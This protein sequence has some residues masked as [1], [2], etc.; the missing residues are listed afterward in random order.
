MAESATD[1][2]A[3]L[4][5]LQAL[6]AVAYG[7][8]TVTP[9]THKRV[10]ARPE[11]ARAR[12]LRG[13]FGWS[14]EFDEALLPPGLFALLQE[15]NLIEPCDG[16]WKSKVRASTIAGRLF[17]HSAFP[18]V[19]DDSVF[20]G[21]DT[22]RFADFLRAELAGSGAVRRIVDIGA[23]AGVGGIVAAACLP[24]AAIELVDLNEKALRFARVNAAHAGVAAAI[25]VSDGVAAVPAGFDLA[26]ANP[27]FIVDEDG[28]AYR[29]GGGNRGAGLSLDWALGAAQKLARGGRILLYTGSAI[30]GG[31]DALREALE[32][33]LPPRGCSLSYRE[34]DPDIFGEELE[35][36]AYRE[37]ERIAAVG[38]VIV[39]DA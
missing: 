29:H 24:G 2:E 36:P 4:R 38:A 9:E 32:T 22:L 1:E 18:T 20:L 30:V 34:I 27:P 14:L 33:G 5:L 31:R 7:F 37:V 6:D 23:G 10:L 35:K 19:E 39:K 3:A 8:V 11:M 28:P 16:A 13:V 17:L 25:Y 15:A 21:P 12:D 26:I